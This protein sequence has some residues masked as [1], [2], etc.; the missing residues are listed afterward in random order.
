VL[1]NVLVILMETGV[2]HEIVRDL[3]P[4]RDA[5]LRTWQA[6]VAALFALGSEESAE[7]HAIETVL[8]P[9][10]LL[11]QIHRHRG[12]GL[13]QLAFVVPELNEPALRDAVR[14]AKSGVNHIGLSLQIIDDITDF[15]EDLTRRNH[16]MLRSWIVFRHPDGPCSDAQLA[17]MS[18]ELRRQPERAFPRATREVMKVAIEMALEGFDIINEAGHPADRGAALQLIKAM[19]KLRGLERLWSIYE[20]AE[21]E[22]RKSDDG[23]ELDYREYFPH[24]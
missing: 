22:A 16:N 24:R 11:D 21:M 7:E 9:K 10:D 23:D 12:G 15:D 4:D 14:M 19:F 3:A 18:P 8:S 6:L 13:L 2:L 1:P 17:A 20:Q 5:A